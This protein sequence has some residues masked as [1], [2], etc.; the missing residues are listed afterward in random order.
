MYKIYINGNCL[1]IA[2]Q[3]QTLSPE[4]EQFKRIPFFGS[5]K[6]LLNYIDKLEKNEGPLTIALV[7]SDP[8]Q[9]FRTT[10]SIYKR[11]KAAGGIISNE[12]GDILFIERL[13]VWDLPKGKKDKG[14]K[15]AE[16]ALREV[17][18]ETGLTCRLKQKVGSTF[19]T[20][21]DQKNRRILKKTV[22][23]TM[24]A[25]PGQS[26]IIQES[27]NITAYHWKSTRDF[28]ISDMPTYPSIRE[29]LSKTPESNLYRS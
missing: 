10:K 9:L 28:L 24:D 20:Y 13:G 17:K 29:I 5:H 14:E 21:Y 16:T 15:T 2:D 25:L 6:H 4:N 12:D 8:N 3:F 22:W 7:T 23:F 26:V 1:L 18:E 11:I 19:H 27:E